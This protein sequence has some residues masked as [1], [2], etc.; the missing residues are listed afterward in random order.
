LFK[1]I[2]NN[3]IIVVLIV[4]TFFPFQVNASSVN[5]LKTTKFFVG[6]R[7]NVTNSVDSGSFE[8][9]VFIS[10]RD[11]EMKSAFIEFSGVSRETNENQLSITLTAYQINPTVDPN[12]ASYVK[13]FNV[14][15]NSNS[16]HFSIL[17]DAKTAFSP[18]MLTNPGQYRYKLDYNL[19][20]ASVSL[21]GAKCILTYKY[22]LP[23]GNYAEN[24]E[25]FSS[26]Y[27]TGVSVAY[28]SIWWEV[29]SKPE[30]TNIRL[31]LAS[32]DNSSGPWNFVGSDGTASTYYTVPGEA[33]SVT[34]NN[35]RYIK[36]KVL[37]STS[38]PNSTPVVGKVII[39]YS[40]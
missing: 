11:P 23:S 10:E 33:I 40:P 5:L 26:V 9:E 20:G 17:Y 4:T 3:F 38:D 6:Q 36:Y 14:K 35:E 1:K 28:N 15:T 2:F 29:I 12:S 13:S 16:S 24:G 21:I 37:L 7:E 25:I 39:N 30:N 34:H 19:N 32:S 8:F 31:Q 22:S 18:P 27:D